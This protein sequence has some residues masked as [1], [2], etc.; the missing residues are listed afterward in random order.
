[1]S[2]NQMAWRIRTDTTPVEGGTPVWAAFQNTTAVIAPNTPVRLRI[3]ID[4]PGSVHAGSNAYTIQISQNGGAYT[5]IGS[6]ADGSVAYFDATGGASSDGS[7]ISTSYLVYADTFAGDGYYSIS[8]TSGM[9][10][11]P[12]ASYSEFEFGLRFT[13]ACIGSNYKFR[14]YANGSPITTYPGQPS[15]AFPFTGTL[16]VTEVGDNLTGACNVPFA[17]R[18]SV[19]EDSDSLVGA[20]NVQATAMQLNRV[21]AN[22][23]ITAQA[24]SIIGGVFQVTE[25]DDAL[26]GAGTVAPFNT[27]VGVLARTEAGDTPTG[28][29][30]VSGVVGALTRTEGQDILV[31]HGYLP[32]KAT[33]NVHEANDTV[34]SK[35]RLGANQW[36]PAPPCDDANWVP[37]SGCN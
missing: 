17:G 24:R 30:T 4:N 19:L 9:A 27:L 2:L 36:I 37:V 3:A 16:S 22:D 32:A 29:G 14:V 11:I 1:M 33:L 7:L 35:T 6:V 8:D 25:A 12:G 5:S 10:D 28:Q 23:A 13:T 20:G 31:G 21:E 18:L 15:F 26:R 34:A